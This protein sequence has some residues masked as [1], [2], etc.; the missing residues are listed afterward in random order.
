MDHLGW[1][2]ITLLAVLLLSLV[3]GLWRGFV[4]EVLALVGWVAAYLGAQWLTPNWAPHVPIDE[5]GSSLNL[6]ATFALA[7][8]VVLVGWGLASRVLRL[9]VNATPLRGADRV[10]G[11][12]FGLA[13]GVLL[14][15]SLATVIA[16]TPAASSPLWHG[17]HGAQWLTVALHELKPLLPPDIAQFLPT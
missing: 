6:A 17:S 14:L 3:L 4:L 1:V 16:L 8:I 11:A 10:L 7:F 5:P 12:A 15:L 9:L 13:R 2:D